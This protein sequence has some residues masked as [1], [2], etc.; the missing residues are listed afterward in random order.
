MGSISQPLYDSDIKLV[1]GRQLF[2]SPK[3]FISYFEKHI[4]W[5]NQNVENQD[6]LTGKMS[7]R[8]HASFAYI[9][10]MKSMVSGIVFNNA[11]ISIS[12]VNLKPKI[13]VGS[14]LNA[15]VR[16]LGKDWTFM[17]DTMTGIERLDNVYYLLSNVISKKIPGDY[18]ETGVWRGGSII[19]AKAVITAFGE[20]ESRVIYVCDSFSG[21]P[22]GN[23][24]LDKHDKN[25][26]NKPYL[27]VPYEVVATNFAKY[28]LLDSQ[29][30]FVKGLFRDTMP[31][32]SKKITKL[33]II[34]LDGDMYE[35]TVD[36][37]YQFYDKLSIG[38][39]VIVD[40]W[41]GFPARTACEDFFQ[42][43]G[44]NPDII[45]I[46]KLAVYW[47]KKEEVELQ[48]WRYEKSHFFG[49]IRVD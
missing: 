19:F 38:G 30:V 10:L 34:R 23:R 16:K 31:P 32:L 22:P 41:F 37:L 48:H 24:N 29:V 2:D 6:K 9:Q 46:D 21:L 45:T 47:E 1:D 35:S 40:D 25:W 7:P 33:S 18:I 20:N 36:V 44:I 26:D 39:F 17:G 11:E 8:E 12:P 3:K 13:Q 27:E 4:V 28:G 42:V 15:E 43:H 14:T 49:S 5:A